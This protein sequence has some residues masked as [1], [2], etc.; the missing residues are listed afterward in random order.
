MKK[1]EK[2]MEKQERKEPKKVNKKA[3]KI[4]LLSIGVVLLVL[5]VVIGSLFL[6]G[7]VYVSKQSADD[8]PLHVDVTTALTAARWRARASRSSQSTTI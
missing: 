4:A 6:A 8:T 1:A 3:L 2:S 7:H 5:L